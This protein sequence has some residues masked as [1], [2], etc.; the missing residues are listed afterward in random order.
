MS[1]NS[2]VATLS[3]DALITGLLDCGVDVFGGGMGAPGVRGTGSWWGQETTCQH[4]LKFLT[5]STKT[6]HYSGHLNNYQNNTC[7]V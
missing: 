5:V 7:K 4:T 3:G 2:F 1:V 6:K